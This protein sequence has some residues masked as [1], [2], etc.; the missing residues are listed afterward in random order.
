MRGLPRLE[1]TTTFVSEG[2]QGAKPTLSSLASFPLSTPCKLVHGR[3]SVGFVGYTPTEIDNSPQHL[4]E[5]EEEER[6]GAV[7]RG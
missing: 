3:C 7:F 1:G 6:R 2:S 4:P 5:E